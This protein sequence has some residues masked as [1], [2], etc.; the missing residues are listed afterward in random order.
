MK[1]INKINLKFKNNL[2]S[3]LNR[4]NKV[5]LISNRKILKDIIIIQNKS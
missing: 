1:G 5:A 4:I 3:E 2:E